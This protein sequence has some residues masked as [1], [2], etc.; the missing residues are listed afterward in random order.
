MASGW[1]S[2]AYNKDTDKKETI[3]KSYLQDFFE[4]TGSFTSQAFSLDNEYLL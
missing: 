3:S 1:F 4:S 2:T